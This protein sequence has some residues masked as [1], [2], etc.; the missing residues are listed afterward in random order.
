MQAEDA[1][2]GRGRRLAATRT[3]GT[4]A[5]EVLVVVRVVGMTHPFAVDA[6]LGHRAHRPTTRAAPMPN[7]MRP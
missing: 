2:L 5:R 6:A 3:A 1:R 7:R 4:L